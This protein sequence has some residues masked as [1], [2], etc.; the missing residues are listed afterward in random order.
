M[1]DCRSRL[2]SWPRSSQYRRVTTLLTNNRLS[3]AFLFVASAS[4]TVDAGCG[5]AV[6][7]PLGEG[8]ASATNASSNSSSAS[9]TNS[10]SV[11]NS[12]STGQVCN[13]NSFCSALQECA[14]EFPQC[15]EV[16]EN[17]A[18]EPDV[19]DCTCTANNC[20]EVFSCIEEPSVAVSVNSSSGSGGGGGFSPQCEQCANQAVEQQCNFEIQQC[21]SLPGCIEIFECMGNCGWQAGCEQQCVNGPPP[22]QDAFFSVIDCAICNACAGPCASSDISLLCSDQGG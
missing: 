3:L 22:A 1:L 15:V 11:N 17:G 9:N 19:M 21:G 16:C 8:G 12:S 4:L 20:D 10:S 14:G 13:C 6:L 2:P 7:G 5:R 18:F